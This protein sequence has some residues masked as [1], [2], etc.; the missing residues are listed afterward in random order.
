[1]KKFIGGVLLSLSAVALMACS[2]G[3]DNTGKETSKDSSSATSSSVVDPVDEQYVKKGKLLEVG[4]WTDD[5]SYGGKI[6]LTKLASPKQT[7]EIADGFSMLI[8]DVKILKYSE[9]D[10]NLLESDVSDG[11]IPESSL[12][13]DGFHSIQ[14][15]YIITNDT[16][17]A[18]DYNGLSYIVTDQGQQ[19]DV[20]MENLNYSNSYTFQPG[21]TVENY[22]IATVDSESINELKKITLTT[23]ELWDENYDAQIGNEE[24]IEINL[25]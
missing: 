12:T 6:T 25:N 23:S 15:D 19:I 18:L 7:I 21:T 24:N 16:E 1:M 10:E 22:V 5:D 4:Q 9:T 3:V 17:S 20:L 8:N 13:D 2:S 14:I 11:I